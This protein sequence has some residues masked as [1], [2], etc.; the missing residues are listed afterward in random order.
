MDDL[1]TIGRFS[2][3]TGLTP[4]ALRLYEKR[5]LLAPATTDPSTGYRFYSPGQV[6]D[7]RLIG[8]LRTIDMPL[9]TISEVL[10]A[11]ADER[12]RVI[13]SYWYSRELGHEDAR[14][15]VA[16]LRRLDDTPTESRFGRVPGGGPIASIFELAAVEGWDG[17]TSA[18]REAMKQAYWTEHDVPSMV[19]LGCAGLA[20]A[21]EDAGAGDEEALSVAKSIAYDLAS[22]TWPGWGEEG[23]VI[24]ETD[25]AIGR[26][27]AELNLHLAHRLEKGD[28]V[29]S[30]ALWMLGA[31]QMVTGD[32]AE[33]QQL[34][35]EASKR[36]EAAAAR[37]ES[38]LSEAFRLLS[39]ELAGDEVAEEMESVLVELRGLEE[40]DAFADQVVTARRVFQTL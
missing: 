39:R 21:L 7:G 25:L 11:V 23:V 2:E 9:Q 38:M 10:E 22:F 5:G 28:L 40:G 6:D 31:H 4:K 35:E 12:V 30:R 13:S 19:A 1:L 36:A 8:M 27:A 34:F 24:G 33:A 37:P 15:K 26:S 20:L 18:Y 14:A 29:V 3:A 17:S 16:S 32:L